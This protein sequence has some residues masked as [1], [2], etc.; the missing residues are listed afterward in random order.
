MFFPTTLYDTPALSPHD[1]ILSFPWLVQHRLSINA[2][3]RTL[4]LPQPGCP[5]S[6]VP[7]PIVL[8]S[9]VSSGVSNFDSFSLATVSFQNPSPPAT[10]RSPPENGRGESSDSTLEDTPPEFLSEFPDDFLELA[11]I[12]TIN[13]AKSEE[14]IQIPIDPPELVEVYRKKIHDA[15]DEIVLR[16]KIEPDPPIRGPIGYAEIKIKPGFTPKKGKQIV[17]HGERRLGMEGLVKEWLRDKKIEPAF[18]AWSSPGFPVQKKNGSWRGV[19][20]YRQLNL[21]TEDDSHPLPRIEDILLRFGDRVLYSIVDLKDA[22]HQIVLSEESRSF[23]CMSTPLETFRWRVMPQGCKNGPTTFQRIIEQALE[24]VSDVAAPYFDDILIGTKGVVGESTEDLF[25]RH[26]ADLRRTLDCLKEHRFARDK[27]K[28]D[29]FVREV[30]FCGHILG[31]GYRRPA[32]G[33][34]LAVQKWGPPPTITA[35]RGFL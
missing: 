30:E 9:L 20:D 7:R 21:A 27:K 26:E 3:D 32:P 2:A 33:K 12:S 13:Y 16:D 1:A 10:P 17:L 28:C 19:I 18:G 34:L 15:Y 8:Q 4:S 22:F 31:G 11:S 14:Q 29:L 24:S 25:K 23:T 5:L 6:G 35:L